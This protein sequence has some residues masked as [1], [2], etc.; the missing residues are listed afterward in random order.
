M[1]CDDDILVYI[2]S[3]FQHSVIFYITLLAVFVYTTVYILS[4]EIIKVLLEIME[5]LKQCTHFGNYEY[6]YIFR[7][8][9]TI[10]FQQA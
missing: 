5:K 9:Y 2:P 1:Q 3:V 4:K 8:V 10:L 6:R 7:I